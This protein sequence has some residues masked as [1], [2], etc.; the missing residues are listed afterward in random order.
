MAV[1]LPIPTASFCPPALPDLSP[2]PPWV[3]LDN[4]AY[5]AKN[6]NAT[7][8]R[9]RSTGGDVVEV[10]FCL[11][12]PPAVSHLCICCPGLEGRKQGGFFGE[13]VVA[14]A[15]GAFVL[16][17]VHFNFGPRAYSY[18]EG[19]HDLFVY[20]AGPGT[21]RLR[22]LPDPFPLDIK[23]WETG[24]LPV[25][26]DGGGG[27]GF[28]VASL[29][30]NIGCKRGT[31]HPYHLHLFESCTGAWR[32]VAPRLDAAS[33]HD[34]RVI[35]HASSKVVAMGG[36]LLG[37]V[38]LLRGILLCDVLADDP[39]LRLL[40][41]PKPMVARAWKSRPAMI[42]DVTSDGDGLLSFVEIQFPKDTCEDLPPSYWDM[43]ISD[44]DS[45][46]DSDTAGFSYVS[47]GWRATIW[48]RKLFS[49]DDR[50]TKDCTATSADIISC[51]P[52]CFQLLPEL[53]DAEDRGLSLENLDSS[54]PIVSM[55]DDGVVYMMSE[56][57][58]NNGNEAWMAAFDVRRKELKAMAPFSSE[59]KY[60][61]ENTCSRP[62][63]FSM[64]LC[65]PAGEL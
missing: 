31:R 32:T 3:L 27:G 20:T 30:W 43:S 10:S 12:A 28:V 50:W 38:D 15:E 40:P 33:E 36:G 48:K 54:T 45:D 24:I 1:R 65:M 51:D 34:D 7:T 18:N 17:D 5:I 19:I 6:E 16:L 62:C 35:S 37:W 22:S 63:S 58:N 29:V 9:G 55:H 53:W 64:Y 23:P 60:S 57:M 8:A 42:R 4:T 2:P 44:S 52:T 59:R 14:A 39:V 56:R 61:F 25:G 46:S 41:L 49:S 11:A 47:H 21:P 13:P 26:G